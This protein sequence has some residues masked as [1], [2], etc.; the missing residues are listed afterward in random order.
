MTTPINTQPSPFTD[1]N[2]ALREFNAYFGSLRKDYGE[3][4]IRA[5]GFTPARFG[6][7]TGLFAKIADGPYC[8]AR[9]AP[10]GVHAG[11]RYVGP[12]DNHAAGLNAVLRSSSRTRAAVTAIGNRFRW[13]RR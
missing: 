10:S 2:N 13:H 9:A 11:A 4:A 7:A 3:D 12:K 5:M 1:P 6:R 8:H